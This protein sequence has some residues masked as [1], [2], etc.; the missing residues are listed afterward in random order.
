ML[1]GLLFE[2]ITT[3]LFSE[4][5]FIGSSERSSG[6]LASKLLAIVESNGASET[7][8]LFDKLDHIWLFILKSE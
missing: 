1:F 6:M 2:Y 8:R 5:R 7:L 3:L 4:K